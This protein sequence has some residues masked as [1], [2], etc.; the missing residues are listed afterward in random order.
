MRMDAEVWRDVVVGG[1]VVAAAAAEILGAF[2][3]NAGS[4]VGRRGEARARRLAARLA[5]NSSPECSPE[6]R[7][8]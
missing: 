7:D 5:A 1:A 3:L 2:G 8:L 4:I 6:W